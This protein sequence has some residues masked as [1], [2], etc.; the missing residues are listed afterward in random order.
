MQGEEL[1]LFATVSEHLENIRQEC[2]GLV[3]MVK[4][5]P[6]C[7]EGDIMCHI[8]A[9]VH[10]AIHETLGRDSAIWLEQQGVRLA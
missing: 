3:D 1:N 5:E 8:Y 2:Q 6:E 7:D 9:I 4:S 10:A